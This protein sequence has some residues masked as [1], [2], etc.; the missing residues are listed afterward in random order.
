MQVVPQPQFSQS[1]TLAARQIEDCRQV[2]SHQSHD[3]R[4]AHRGPVRTAPATG[5]RKKRGY[6]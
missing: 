4:F 5:S 6:P 2:P 1:I 3:A